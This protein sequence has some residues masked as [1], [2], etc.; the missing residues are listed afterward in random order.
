MTEEV[1]FDEALEEESSIYTAENLFNRVV[2]LQKQ[3]ITIN[4]DMK[5]LQ[6]DFTAGDDN[7]KG[8]PKDQVKEVVDFA[9]AVA[10]DGVDKV[11][12]K[13]NNYSELKSEFVTKS[14]KE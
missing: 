9:K 3:L 5:Q 6:A 10:K 2:Y 7:P 12:E 4:D 1:T 11:I 14:E 8:L 13:G